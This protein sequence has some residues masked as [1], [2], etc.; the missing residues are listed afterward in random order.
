MALL[1]LLALASVT[2]SG[3]DVA[4]VDWNVEC[5]ATETCRAT[6]TLVEGGERTT[7]FRHGDWDVACDNTG[8]C[9]AAGYHADGDVQHVSVLLTRQAGPAQP[10]T[11]QLRLEG[12]EQSV[13]EAVTF[14]IDGRRLGT[15]ALHDGESTLSQ[16]HVSALLAALRRDS[17]IAFLAGGD[18]WRLSGRGA[19]A[20]LL[21]MDEVQGR[22][23]TPG[24]LVRRGTR[25]EAT[26]PPARPAPVIGA[27]PPLPPLLAA[28]E[29]LAID[30][31]YVAAMSATIARD[32]DPDG[33][34]PGW[35]K[36]MARL[37]ATQLLVE[38][39]CWS[40]PYNGD[41]AF[42]VVDAAPPYAATLVTDIG[43]E[44]VDGEIVSHQGVQSHDCDTADAWRWNGRAFVRRV[45]YFSGQCKGFLGGAWSQPIYVTE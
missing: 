43:S 27:A 40:A 45:V 15:L 44:F 11:G 21:R 5:D 12:T 7:S 30:P 3:D 2:P 23:D 6:G 14:A 13:P 37:S 38:R 33:K 9:R 25:A 42:W 18:R 34:Y 16:A 35:A 1:L 17:R 31:A 8:T 19:S 28:D 29:A 36:P 41:Q 10:V 32:C 4:V 22:L 39:T 20:V 24:A 26:V